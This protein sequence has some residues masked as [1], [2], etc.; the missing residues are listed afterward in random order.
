MYLSS[1]YCHEICS[2]LWNYPLQHCI[3]INL[4]WLIDIFTQI[5]KILGWTLIRHRYL[6]DVDAR[7]FAVWVSARELGHLREGGVFIYDFKAWS[8]SCFCYWHALTDW[9]RDK[10]AAI[11]QTT[12]SNVFSSTKMLKF[13]WIFHLSLFLR[14]QLTIFRHWFR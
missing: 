9:G 13:R 10:I 12:L 5:P 6:I 3:K 7:I 4:F 2:K 1:L 11:S 14:V 8:N